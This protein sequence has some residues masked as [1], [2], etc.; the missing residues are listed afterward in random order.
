MLASLRGT[1]LA[2]AAMFLWGAGNSAARPPAHMSAWAG[3]YFASMGGLLVLAIAHQF[4][5]LR[6]GKDDEPTVIGRLALGSLLSAL[7]AVAVLVGGLVI[8]LVLGRGDTHP[9]VGALVRASW[10]ALAAF[11]VGTAVTPGSPRVGPSD[12]GGE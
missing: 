10:H 5:G 7:L 1:V 2:V 3:A 9:W 6:S 8:E 4:L 11:T 12:N